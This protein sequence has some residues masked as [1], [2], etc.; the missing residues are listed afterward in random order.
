MIP[1]H[2][3][4][5]KRFS[6]FSLC[7]PW[8]DLLSFSL[9]VEVEDHGSWAAEDSVPAKER[10]EGSWEEEGSGRRPEDCCQ[11]RA[12]LHLPCL[13]GNFHT[14]AVGYSLV[15]RSGLFEV[16]SFLHTSADHKSHLV[17]D[18]QVTMVISTLVLNTDLHLRHLYAHSS[19]SAGSIDI[20]FSSMVHTSSYIRPVHI[21]IWNKTEHCCVGA[22][23]IYLSWE[24]SRSP[25]SY[26]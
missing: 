19:A 3:V 7:S 25:G 1:C 20:L 4:R 26:L 15:S 22:C 16:Q 10:Q 11:G 21:D 13:S 9:Q 12:G 18:W 24:I 8:F 5:C 14:V 17:I 6:C 2:V 23:G